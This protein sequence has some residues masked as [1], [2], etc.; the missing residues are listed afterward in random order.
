MPIIIMFI[1]TKEKCPKERTLHQYLYILKFA[2]FYFIDSEFRQNV[3]KQYSISYYKVKMY[4]D[5]RVNA[6]NV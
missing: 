1:I 5:T 6:F 2:V 4:Y 3:E